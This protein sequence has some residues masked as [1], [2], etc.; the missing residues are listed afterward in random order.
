[1]IYSLLKELLFLVG[2]HRKDHK[3]ERIIGFLSASAL[4]LEENPCFAQECKLFLIAYQKMTHALDSM[5]DVEL[6]IQ[7]E[8]DDS[9]GKQLESQSNMSLGPS[10]FFLELQE[11][12][13]KRAQRMVEKEPKTWEPP[14]L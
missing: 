9:W 10:P 11:A 13:A 7:P 2:Q 12:I 8:L 4:I 6:K 5:L 14:K 1:M 3:D